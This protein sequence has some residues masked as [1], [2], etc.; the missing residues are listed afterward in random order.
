MPKFKVL[1]INKHHDQ[2]GCP[3]KQKNIWKRLAYWAA[4]QGI[5]ILL[6]SDTASPRLEKKLLANYMLTQHTTAFIWSVIDRLKIGLHTMALNPLIAEKALSQLAHE[7]E[8]R[9][10]SK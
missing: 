3:W 4:Q 8:G 6:L 7:L 9:L 10:R 2:L 1:F 5:P